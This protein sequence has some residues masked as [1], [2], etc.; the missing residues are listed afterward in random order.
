MYTLNT[1]PN[2]GMSVEN[3]RLT[4]IRQEID[5]HRLGDEVQQNRSGI[6]SLMQI[7]SRVVTARKPALPAAVSTQPTAVES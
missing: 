2:L 6:K 7:I 4:E 5:A 3:T 1:N